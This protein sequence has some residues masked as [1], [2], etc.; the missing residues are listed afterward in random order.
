MVV[1]TIT[2]GILHKRDGVFSI[3]VLE[4][5]SQE[6][7]YLCLWIKDPIDGEVWSE[8]VQISTLVGIKSL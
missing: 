3:D 8:D 7:P 1:E 5:D 2:N 4:N 6:G